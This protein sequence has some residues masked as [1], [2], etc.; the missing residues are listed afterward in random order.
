MRRCSRTSSSASLRAAAASLA[1]ALA[2]A[3]CREAPAP[4]LLLIVSDTLRADALSCYGGPA[5]TPNICSLAE[6][7]A[8]FE[9]S[10]A[11][12]AWTLPSSVALFTGQHPNGFARSAAAEKNDFYLV[13]E[14]EELLAE[15]LAAR[16]YRRVAFVE[17]QVVLRPQALQGFEV[18]PVWEK[19]WLRA[20]HESWAARAGFDLRDFRY[21]QIAAPLKFLREEARSPFFALV[22][23]MDPHAVY[24]PER[25][26]ASSLPFDFSQLPHPPDYYARLAASDVP[27]N[28]WLDFNR[29]APEMSQAEI[30]FTRLLYHTEVESVDERVGLLLHALELAGLRDR[31]IV[32]FTSDHGEGFR[33]H[34]L[35]FHSDRRLYEEFVRVPWIAAGPGIAAG[36]RYAL[37]V[38]H[39]DL[40][41]TLREL[42]GL[43][44]H[45]AHQGRSLAALLRGEP[46]LPPPAVQYIS[47][48]SR[49]HG[50]AALVDGRHKLL[51]EPDGPRLYDLE[52]DPGETRDL[53]AQVPERA[54]ALVA[55]IEELTQEDERRRQA[56]A[57]RAD[58]E[59]LR[60]IESETLEELRAL[61]YAE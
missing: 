54:A 39:L 2:L 57:A 53:A 46:A 43:P 8:L 28:D 50:Y 44:R 22:W 59:T 1:L 30:D 10:W 61:G 9:R 49:R 16:G 51:L 14:A 56:R 47:G 25:R 52:A 5:R 21:N 40:M 33:E 15:S 27:K 41:P 58:A 19:D 26:F 60:R 31:S 42:L 20:N 12:G 18:P 4:N 24:A 6:R 37:P 45:E 17:N 7:G 55:R 3:S 34:G 13:D 38:S 29:L 23:I 11:N 36:R 48:N 35:V 32:V